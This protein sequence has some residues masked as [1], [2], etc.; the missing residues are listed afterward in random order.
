MSFDD[1]PELRTR[2]DVERAIRSARS[3]RE[4][5][6]LVLS[7]AFDSP[8]PARLSRELDR[9]SAACGCSTAAAAAASGFLI[10][11]PVL[12]AMRGAPANWSLVDGFELLAFVV[13][14]GAGGK[15]IGLLR[16]RRRW[17]GALEAYGTLLESNTDDGG[18]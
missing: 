7:A 12:L 8:V 4:L 5:P 15:M 18:H 13:L 11:A 17:F 10:G 3:R 14:A 16:A 9:S 2:M 6:K 1:C